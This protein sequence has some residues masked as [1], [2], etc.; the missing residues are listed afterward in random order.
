[1]KQLIYCL[2]V[3]FAI[4]LI[5]SACNE[6]EIVSHN[7]RQ[8]AG[9][10]NS[11]MAKDINVSRTEANNIADLFYCSNFG[12]GFVPTKSEDGPYLCHR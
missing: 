9:M 6:I 5:L 4:I 11:F 8:L 10:Q 3:S 2:T 1:M 7:S 12:S